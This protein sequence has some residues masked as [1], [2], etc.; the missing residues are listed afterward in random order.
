[1]NFSALRLNRSQ[2]VR[3]AARSR[4]VARETRRPRGPSFFGFWTERLLFR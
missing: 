3:L 4:I 2:Q 1:M